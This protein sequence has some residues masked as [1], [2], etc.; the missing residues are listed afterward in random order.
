MKTENFKYLKSNSK[1]RRKELVNEAAE[2]LAEIFIKQIEWEK[3]KKKK[4]HGKGKV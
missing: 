3:D 1:K 2:R 4:K